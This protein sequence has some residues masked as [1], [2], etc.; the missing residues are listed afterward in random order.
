MAETTLQPEESPSRVRWLMFGLA[1]G[2]SWFLYLHRYAWAIVLPAIQKAHDL[3]DAQ[4]GA[5]TSLFYRTYAVGQIPSGVVI[6]LFGP[7]L[8]LGASI[9]LWS[10]ALIGFGMFSSVSGVGWLR[11]VFGAAQAGC[12]PALTKATRVW[13]PLR[14]R[15]TVQGWVAT[16]FG[17][18][19]GAMSSIILATVL[20]GWC[21]LSLQT[22]LLVMG[23]S[24]VAFGIAFLLLYRD[25]P[26]NHPR[27]NDAERALISEGGATQS[28]TG[29]LPWSKAIRSRSLQYFMV[30]QFLDAGSD[31]L[32]AS[33]IATYFMRRHNLDIKNVGW[34]TSLPLWGGALGGIAG[35]WLNDRLIRATGNR[36]WS[37]SGI[38]CVGKVI[39]CVMLY[40]V[41]SQ[42]GAVAAGIA[43]MLA[44][45]FSDW[46]QPTVWGTCTDMGGRCSATVFSIINTA[47]TIGG[48]VM[49][50]IFGYV[51]QA[52]TIKTI[53]DGQT[54]LKTDWAPL[55]VLVAAMYLAC[56]IFWLLIDCTKSLDA[57]N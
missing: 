52:N 23:L 2:T 5:L 43:L 14:S 36:R 32:F 41:S 56:A 40:I 9:L 55:F 45:F 35:G 10:I 22:S 16:T 15:T 44:K 19:G 8:F 1:C 57:E 39:G 48:M 51:L 13:F 7:H 21:E 28:L 18:A 38:G 17:R 37:R 33:L 53:V 46:S 3:D 25:S 26:A 54:I 42:E 50:V 6:D 47:G 20:M 4:A 12:Y 29:T 24:G 49:P 30:Q 27:V 31:L 11:L 34:L